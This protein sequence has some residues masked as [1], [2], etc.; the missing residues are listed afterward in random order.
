MSRWLRPLGRPAGVEL[1]LSVM[2][3]VT[4]SMWYGIRALFGV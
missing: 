1:G 4:P 3:F 2:E